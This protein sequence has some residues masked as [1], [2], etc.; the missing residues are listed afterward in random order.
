MLSPDVGGDDE[1]VSPSK[2]GKRRSINM[3]VEVYCE[4]EDQWVDVDLFKGRVNAVDSIR[5]SVASSNLAYVF[6]FNNDSTLK[7]VTP[8]YCSQWAAT[9]RKCRVEQAWLDE[10]IQKYVIKKPTQRDLTEDMDLRRIHLDKPM[11]TTISEYKDHPLYALERHLLK[12]QVL[13]PPN[14]L[15]LGFVRGEPVYA[16]ECVHTCHSRE[17][18]LK[19][20]RVVKLGEQPYKIVK[21]RPKW[22]RLTNSVIKDQP[23]EI[24]GYWQTQEY[25][26]PTAEN[27]LVPR[28][29]YGNVELFKECM[30]PKKTVHLHLP[31]LNRVCKKLG[32]DCAS[33]VIGFDFHQGSCHPLYD[34]F[35][36]CEEFAETVVDAWNKEQE[37]A[38]R[39]EQNKYEARVYGNWKKL[40]KGLLIRERLKLKYNF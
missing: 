22:D 16:R 33:A 34:G 35:V 37:E 30:L 27:G 10:A 21:A 1:D 13:Y 9:L 32:I 8:R 23:L 7:D 28:N 39:K 14:A 19:E 17:I 29:A 20:A 18:W 31:G 24:F 4:L 2:G 5:K 3:W 38:E 26:P 25:E 12:F 15:T 6:A 40:I 36:V 11:P